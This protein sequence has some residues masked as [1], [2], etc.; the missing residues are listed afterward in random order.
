LR[1]L[2]DAYNVIHACAS[3]KA[4]AATNFES[5]RD[6]LTEMAA[7]LLKP[8]VQVV[9]V[10]DGQGATTDTS[11]ALPGVDRME[12]VFTA[13]NL[14]ADTWIE[15]TV[16]NANKRNL[17]TV[18]TADGGIRDLCRGLGA[19]VFTP[20][21]FEEETGRARADTAH[22]RQSGTTG[23]SRELGD[24]LDTESRDRLSKLRDDI[25]KA[26]ETNGS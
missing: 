18:I 13:Q 23:M 21:W 1:Y 8:D 7:A 26:N 24:R 12:V 19:R 22:S 4:I 16:H 15:R 6:A 3:L 11:P 5:S 17:C 20:G 9:I 14:S 2:I 10:F 25:E